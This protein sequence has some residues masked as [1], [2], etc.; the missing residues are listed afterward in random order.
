MKHR[1]HSLIL[2]SLTGLLAVSATSCSGDKFGKTRNPPR[3]V[4]ELD[5]ASKAGSQD[6]P[7]PLLVDIP[8]SF[9]ASVRAFEANGAVDTSLANA[10]PGSAGKSIVPSPSL[11]IPSAQAGG[12]SASGSFGT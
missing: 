10:Q 1:T 2:A 11:S 8:V 3:L 5:P 4:V 9:R 7:L 6:T 12:G